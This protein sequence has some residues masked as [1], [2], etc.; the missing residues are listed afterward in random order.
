MLHLLEESE[1]RTRYW[2]DREEK[3]PQHPAWFEPTA[4]MFWGLRSTVANELL[5]LNV[6]CCRLPRRSWTWPRR[7]QRWSERRL[8]IVTPSRAA[9]PTQPPTFHSL[10]LLWRVQ[11]VADGVECRHHQYSATSFCSTSP[12][13]KREHRGW[14]VVVSFGVSSSFLFGSVVPFCL[15][16]KKDPLTC[17]LMIF[18]CVKTSTP[19]SWDSFFTRDEFFQPNFWMLLLKGSLRISPRTPRKKLNKKKSFPPTK[20]NLESLFSWPTFFFTTNKSTCRSTA[21]SEKATTLEIKSEPPQTSQ[22]T[23]FLEIR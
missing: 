9:S 2:E 7:S 13:T 16:F 3:I 14:G 6:L 1:I 18:L 19:F 22:P 17:L 20:I 23:I 21:K 8:K 11:D 12:S 15:K 4:P 10:E 5:T